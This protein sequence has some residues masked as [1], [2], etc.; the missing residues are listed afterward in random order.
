MA[1]TAAMPQ[2]PGSHAKLL[3]LTCAAASA[4]NS[5][6]VAAA[7]LAACIRIQSLPSCTGSEAA[8]MAS[9]NP[10]SN[11]V[12]PSVTTGA[13]MISGTSTSRPRC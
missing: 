12:M 5:G 8:E 3:S 2:V 10:I 11:S 4:T 1:S 6:N 13:R 9:M 7:I